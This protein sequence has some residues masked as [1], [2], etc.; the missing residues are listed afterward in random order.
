MIRVKRIKSF[1]SYF[2]NIS[3]M[4]SVTCP[5]YYIT[6]STTGAFLFAPKLRETL[7]GTIGIFEN[8]RLNNCIAQYYNFISLSHSAA[9]TKQ[10][11]SRRAG[12]QISQWWGN[13]GKGGRVYVSMTL[14]WQPSN[15]SS[16]FEVVSYYLRFSLFI[17]YRHTESLHTYNYLV[18]YHHTFFSTTTSHTNNKSI[19]RLPIIILS[20]YN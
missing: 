10:L 7:L 19:R 12:N 2:G 8:K 1:V 16:N 3:T 17:Y 6:S 13:K 14:W 20:N 9:T 5:N 18:Y 15:T 4:G 11:K